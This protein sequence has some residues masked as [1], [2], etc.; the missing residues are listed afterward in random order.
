MVA[1]GLLTMSA[2]EDR[3]GS[4]FFHKGEVI[5]MESR[6]FLKTLERGDVVI[7]GGNAV[8]FEGN[9]GVLVGNETGGTIGALFGIACVRGIPLI[10]PVGLEKLVPSVPDA[11]SGWGQLTLSYA[12]GLPCWLTPVSTG[13]V[14][15]E[16]QALGILAGVRARLV[17]S[18]GIGGS[19]GAVVLLVEG[20]EE[21]LQS[22]I[23]AVNAVKGEPKQRSSQASPELGVGN[24]LVGPVRSGGYASGQ[25]DSGLGTN[26]DA[27]WTSGRSFTPSRSTR[28]VISEQTHHT[29]DR[30]HEAD[31]AGSLE[32]GDEIE[33][34]RE[35]AAVHVG[36]FA[37]LEYERR[38]LVFRF[39]GYHF[40]KVHGRVVIEFALEIDE[41]H[42]EA[43]GD[44]CVEVHGL[45]PALGRTVR[46]CHV[47]SSSRVTVTG[48]YPKQEDPSHRNAKQPSGGHPCAGRAV[49]LCGCY[50][51]AD[52][53]QEF[54][55]GAAQAELR[56]LL[57]P[58][59]SFALSFAAV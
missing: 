15:T 52:M 53:R 12:M 11:A 2:K 27:D 1:D 47:P 30:S 33:Q 43:I 16:I 22:A 25:A 58:V 34:Q 57:T 8:D 56:S 19:E 6:D 3:V 31:P 59:C 9:A 35:A 29:R 36:E 7:K 37:D 20:Y 18:G 46:V 48:R 13:L 49:N 54:S 51:R 10:M 26:R 32:G 39:F 50:T 4:K 23:A 45:R 24:S 17:A 44:L 21:N 14:V 55:S 28:P 41:R 38:G 40:A 5:E 42:A